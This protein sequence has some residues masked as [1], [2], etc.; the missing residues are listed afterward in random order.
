MTIAGL[1]AVPGHAV[2]AWPAST[3]SHRPGSLLSSSAS[4]SAGRGSVPGGATYAFIPGVS[5]PLAVP[6]GPLAL[7]RTLIAGNGNSKRRPK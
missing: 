7:S 6:P 4:P 5:R 2:R 3:S 1:A